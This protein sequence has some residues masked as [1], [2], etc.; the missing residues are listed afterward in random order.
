MKYYILFL[1]LFLF[2]HTD[3]RQV[4]IL[5]AGVENYQE[6]LICIISN[7]YFLRDNVTQTSS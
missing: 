6:K 7:I 4:V 1:V 5:E 3:T 2:F